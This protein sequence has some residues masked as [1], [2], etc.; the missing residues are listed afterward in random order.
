MKH[1]KVEA[2][3]RKTRGSTMLPTTMLSAPNEKWV[4][5]SNNFKST[6]S[7]TA[8]KTC[9]QPLFQLFGIFT[10]LKKRQKWSS[11]RLKKGGESSMSTSVTGGSTR[12]CEGSSA[13]CQQSPTREL[14]TSEATAEQSRGELTHMAAL[15]PLHNMPP[16]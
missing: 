13:V 5:V 8:L 6:T 2:T 10:C 11:Q 12:Q 16:V 3:N 14:N 9:S 15:R 1:R 4:T 7:T